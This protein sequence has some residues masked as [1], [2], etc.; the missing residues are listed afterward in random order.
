MRLAAV[1]M[2]V[3]VGLIAA[4]A[5]RVPSVSVEEH[6]RLAHEAEELGIEQEALYDPKRTVATIP[7]LELCF[8]PWSNPTEVHHREAKRLWRIA[9]QHQR[10]ARKL[11]VAEER[12][13][14]GVPQ[15]GS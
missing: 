11:R 8:Y 4:C 7:C 12:A 14:L 6:R 10:A 5:P 9:E 13:R 15:P 1:A 2:V 3:G